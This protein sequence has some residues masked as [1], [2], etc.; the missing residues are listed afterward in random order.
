MYTNRDKHI[1]ELFVGRKHYPRDDLKGRRLSFIK[2]RYNKPQCL[3]CAKA[4]NYVFLKRAFCKEHLPKEG[5]IRLSAEWQWRNI[6]LPLA[7]YVDV[8]RWR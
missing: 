2:T 6:V 1:S 8:V 5:K 7:K 3:T 4:A